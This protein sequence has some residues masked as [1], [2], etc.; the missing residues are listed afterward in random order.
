MSAYPTVDG[1]FDAAATRYNADYL[2]DVY[3]RRVHLLRR[4]IQLIDDPTVVSSRPL[5]P[6]T[7]THTTTNSPPQHVLQHQQH[8][9]PQ[10]V[11]SGS[12]GGAWRS[13]RVAAL[14]Q[15]QSH[16]PTN[17]QPMPT[18]TVQSTQPQPP[19]QLH[20]PQPI[21]N[22]AELRLWYY[23]DPQGVIQGA[24]QSAEMSEWFI[25]GYFDVKLRIASRTNDEINRR[26][27][28]AEFV[29][30]GLWFLQG[31]PAF[32]PELPN[33]NNIV[34][35][36]RTSPAQQQQ[37]HHHHSYERTQPVASW[38]Q[39]HHD[40]HESP[41]HL[42]QPHPDHYHLTSHHVP[43]RDYHR[44]PNHVE[45]VPS[46]LVHINDIANLPNAHDNASHFASAPLPRD[47]LNGDGDYDHAM[48]DTR[49]DMRL[50]QQRE[51]Q[52]LEHEADAQQQL[53]PE[54]LIPPSLLSPTSPRLPAPREEPP[55]IANADFYQQTQISQLHPQSQQPPHPQSQ[56]QPEQHQH[57]PMPPQVHSQ[58]QSPVQARTQTPPDTSGPPQVTA[59]L[60]A[61]QPTPIAPV[62]AEPNGTRN[63]SAK[64]MKIAAAP[65]QTSKNATQNT[66]APPAAQPVT[67]QSQPKSVPAKQTSTQPKPKTDPQPKPQPQAVAQPPK[68]SPEPSVPQSVPAPSPS[69]NASR[70]SSKPA[71][72]A[73]TPPIDLRL[74]QSRELESYRAEESVKRA[75]AERERERE[76]EALK[77]AAATNGVVSAWSGR[78][79]AKLAASP[80]VVS[81]KD[82]QAAEAA[83]AEARRVATA[84]AAAAV[85]AS[86]PFTSAWS[87]IARAPQHKTQQSAPQ[88]APPPPP[89]LQQQTQLQPQPAQPSHNIT[90]S[91]PTN[92]AAAAEAF[93][94][95]KARTAA[96]TAAAKARSSG[97]QPPSNAAAM[98]TSATAVANSFGGPPMS[99]AL[100]EWCASTLEQLTGST[101]IT[102][103]QYLMT[104]ESPAAVEEYVTI[105][106]GGGEEVK[107]FA[108]EFV[109]RRNQQNELNENQKRAKKKKSKKLIH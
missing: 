55:I 83:A 90:P 69:A 79:P 80:A 67:A 2:L 95:G 105:Y 28:D 93:W 39:V 91:T 108:T 35:T 18:P 70:A 86:A 101:D 74:I 52:K 49:A 37:Q 31:D 24:F 19:A 97:A 66:A 58:P 84:A 36:Q 6:T 63:V 29:P 26:F 27:D 89:Q 20:P 109:K 72:V 64:T 104:V 102:L 81:L 65:Q 106:L 42:H 3:R 61:Q 99:P 34:S 33:L 12:S 23:L 92:D 75:E 13:S 1:D 59:P 8:H 78:T 100:M 9:S 11:S 88:H 87:G 44:P 76:R 48:T 96:P 46:P 51:Q 103:A 82:I 107:S 77:A 53:R 25:K 94:N 56:T 17:T 10:N 22:G 47:I 16:T 38:G 60:K 15:S 14:K 30:I 45:Q 71:W 7:L 41:A 54:Q 4:P 50:W 5:H 40:R 43:P 32:L 57:Q 68:Q 85:P 62:S 98:Q 73:P 21:H